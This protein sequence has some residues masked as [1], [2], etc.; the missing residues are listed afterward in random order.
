MCGYILAK[1]PGNI[2]SLSEHIA[3]SFREAYFCTVG[4][5][6]TVN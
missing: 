3:K 5:Y 4:L 2:L 6:V 1:F